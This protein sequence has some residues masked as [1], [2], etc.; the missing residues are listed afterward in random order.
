MHVIANLLVCS[1]WT[2][3]ELI[4]IFGRAAPQTGVT[5]QRILEGAKTWEVN[6]AFTS[7]SHQSEVSPCPPGAN[8]SSYRMPLALSLS[9]SRSSSSLYIIPCLQYI[10]IT[11]KIAPKHVQS[12]F[13][14]E[15]SNRGHPE[16]GMTGHGDISWVNVLSLRNMHLLSSL[17]FSPQS[18]FIYL[19]KLHVSC[20][21]KG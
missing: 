20:L 1:V 16:A 12:V 11:E 14:G 3:S 9:D 6:F 10:V 13:H 19:H 21:H 17:T 2:H 8:V 7:G 15:M 18:C 4:I 5:G